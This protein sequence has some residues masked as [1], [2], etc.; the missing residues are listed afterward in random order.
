MARR[1]KKPEDENGADTSND[2]D[3]IETVPRTVVEP[4]VVNN[5]DVMLPRSESRY[6]KPLR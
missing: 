1:K 3:E 4:T 5:N 2:I 6:V